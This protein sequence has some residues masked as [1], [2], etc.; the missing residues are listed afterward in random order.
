MSIKLMSQVWEE[1]DLGGSELLVLLALAD[2]AN[3]NGVCWPS[4]P[5]LAARA[6]LS[7][8]QTQRVLQKLHADGYFEIVSKGDGRGHSTLYR[9]TLKGDTKGDTVST[10]TKERVTSA[11]QRVT[12]AT[13]KGD[14]AMSPEP[15]IEPSI[16]PSTFI[17]SA[18]SKTPTPQQ[19]MF[20]AI[21][22]AIGW[23]YHTIS[24]DDQGQ[25]AQAV[26]ILRKA[27]Y[28]VDD[29]RRFMVEVWFKDWRWEKN[30]QHPTL[31]Q[32]RQEI[33]KIRSVIAAAA[34]AKKL[35]GVDG[36]KEML[37]ERGIQVP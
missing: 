34:P 8:R 4:V 36:Y 6:R 10:F 24:K 23:D 5:R 3:D 18:P 12:S 17:S 14:I 2:H 27:N 16:E 28:T 19:E 9:V 1:A 21:C 37:R 33:G 26:G 30:E 20:A 7:E 29:I 13:V 15:S 25:V 22:E 32:L 31:K 35:T 11:T